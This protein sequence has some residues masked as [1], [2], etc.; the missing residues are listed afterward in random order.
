MSNAPPEIPTPAQYKL[1]PALAAPWSSARPLEFMINHIDLCKFESGLENDQ[2]APEDEPDSDDEEY[3]EAEDPHAIP[4]APAYQEARAL[5][6]LY[7]TTAEGHSVFCAV[8]GFT[9]YFYVEVPPEM[10]WTSFMAQQL[11]EALR[12]KFRDQNK[13]GNAQG[14]A[15]AELVE[16]ENFYGFTNGDK[17]QYVRLCFTS[18]FSF[19]AT[20]SLIQETAIAIPFVCGERRFRLAEYKVSHVQQFLLDLGLTPSGWVRLEAGRYTVSTRDVAISY[21]QIDVRCVYKALTALE[22]NE[23]A[24]FIVASFD[25]ECMRENQ[26]PA[27][28]IMPNAIKPGDAVIQI[29]ITLH[30]WGDARPSYQ[31]VFTLDS[32]DALEGIEIRSF[33]SERALLKAW[34]KYW[35]EEIDADV[36]TGWN[37][38]FDLN[39]LHDRA[40]E[41]CG[42]YSFDELGKVRGE[43]SKARKAR[44]SFRGEEARITVGGRV[45]VDML[46][47]VQKDVSIRLKD[48]GLG[49]VSLHFLND[50]KED[51]DCFLIWKYQL[52]TS[53]HRAQIAFYCAKD[54]L[55]PLRIMLKLCTAPNL[56]EYARVTNVPMLDIVMR[57]QQ[58]KT[59]NLTVREAHAHGILL[60]D[61]P[62]GTLLAPLRASD[63]R[64]EGGWNYYAK[65]EQVDPS[66]YEYVEVPLSKAARSKLKA[67]EAVPTVGKRRKRDTEKGYEGAIVV[68]PIRGYYTEPIPTLDYASLYPS[69]MISFHLCYRTIVLQEQYLGLPGVSYRRLPLKQKNREPYPLWWVENRPTLL[70]KILSDLLAAR[71]RAK[72]EMAAAFE[73]GDNFLGEVLNGRQLAL[74][75][76]ANS[77]YGFTGAD[78]KGMLPC[79]P[80]A[81][82]T[83]YYGRWMIEQTKRIVEEHYPPAQV[84]YGDSV[85]GDTPV[86]CRD[87]Y[88]RVRYVRIDALFSE[89]ESQVLLE[90]DVCFPRKLWTW[91]DLGWTPVRA[92]VR[93]R[94]RNA[95]YRVRT[96]R[97]HVDVTEEHSLLDA[98]GRLV[99]ASDLTRSAQLLFRAPPAAIGTRV[100]K[101]SYQRGWDAGASAQ[102]SAS[103]REEPQVQRQPHLQ[104][105]STLF[106]EDILDWEA[107]CARLFLDGL[108]RYQLK[109]GRVPALSE[110]S[111]ACAI[112]CALLD[113]CEQTHLA[114]ESSHLGARLLDV[115]ALEHSAAPYVYD[116]ETECHHFAAG[117]GQLVVHNTDSVMV[118]FRRGDTR[119]VFLS[120]FEVGEE[121]AQL[122]TEFFAKHTITHAVRLEFEKI[123][124]PYILYRKKGYAAIKYETPNKGCKDV[125]GLA[126]VRRDSCNL[127]SE[128]SDAVGN[129]LLWDR[130]VDKAQKILLQVLD[131]LEN[132]R[133]PLE[134]LILS[135]TLSKKGYANTHQVQAVVAAKVAQ[136]DPARAYRGGDRVHYLVIDIGD[137]NDKRG[138]DEKAED[139]AYVMEHKLKI[140]YL[141][142]VQH[143][144]KNPLVDVLGPVLKDPAVL[145]ADTIRRLHNRQ[146]GMRDIS[147]FFTRK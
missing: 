139:P 120:L 73:S 85:T 21:C 5:Y 12:A 23:V 64:V 94:A 141:W 51:L 27:L 145:F 33:H 41:I 101:H 87:E 8:R 111:V 40:T 122:C 54:T 114:F 17:F 132:G 115:Q 10:R 99:H 15:S 82:A 90:K 57:G 72:R 44:K 123:Y 125:K 11:A 59:Y 112:F 3:D 7:G 31:C 75:V 35:C 69:I 48:Y 60:T 14:I 106:P 24:P 62:T 109:H 92:V 66:A 83:T 117:V 56:L 30:R 55:L 18:M 128:T 71:K 105:Q 28:K 29:G 65:R 144:L 16:R 42:L 131:D 39:Y 20:R 19:N 107:S 95:I 81:A 86:L 1:R 102:A 13:R 129:A 147:S 143:Q 67:F 104:A 32:C 137:P 78:Q 138:L 37:I 97:G 93:H 34:R 53:W 61:P 116:L 140:D 52:M 103:A 2:N 43:R 89:N 113:R 91:S 79:M 45:Q 98:E 126:E 76:V 133:V 46:S 88:G 84:V 63:V 47:V 142:Y 119:E 70:P 9:P 50:N 26:D 136:R 77:V 110:D 74:K 124:W 96:T 6:R 25:I 134:K 121:A 80:V 58:I 68:S 38:G 49:A 22:R 146:S 135:K 100:V 130:D 127:V 4:T 118:N 108:V 36:I